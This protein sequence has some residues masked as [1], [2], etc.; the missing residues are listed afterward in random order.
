[1]KLHS[2][3]NYYQA[4]AIIVTVFVLLIVV[5]I[6]LLIH[7]EVV[8]FQVR[9][10]LGREFPEFKNIGIP[11]KLTP[12]FAYAMNTFHFNSGSPSVAGDYSDNEIDTTNVRGI[13]ALAGTASPNAA[14]SI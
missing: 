4:L 13:D 8:V 11:F 2:D 1:M 14:F 6:G 10:H 5:M 9:R 3:K 12:I 7:Q